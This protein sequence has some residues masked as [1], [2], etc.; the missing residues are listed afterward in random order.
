[1]I[2][3]DNDN[4]DD[5]DDN[6]SHYRVIM[7]DLIKV[8]PVIISVVMWRYI[9]QYVPGIKK[10]IVLDLVV[11]S[12]SLSL[13]HSFTNFIVLYIYLYIYALTIL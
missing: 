8:I 1:M 4:D 12:L 7:I 13:S 5:D 11:V 9:D 6:D 10:W 2:I 3:I